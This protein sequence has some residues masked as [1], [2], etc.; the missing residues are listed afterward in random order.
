MK[1]IFKLCLTIVWRM[2]NK[3]RA[4]GCVITRGVL[5]ESSLNLEP[6]VLTLTVVG[7]G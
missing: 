3:R 2:G 1:Y 6:I 5:V 7:L 4:L